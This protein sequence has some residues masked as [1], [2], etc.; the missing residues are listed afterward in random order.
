MISKE[1]F[2]LSKLGERGQITIPVE[3][4]KYLEI[5]S[6]DYL[7]FEVINGNICLK[8]VE[9]EFKIKKVQKD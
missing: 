4:R 3:I 8:K 1:K 5:E 6:G 2:S 9:I 7:T